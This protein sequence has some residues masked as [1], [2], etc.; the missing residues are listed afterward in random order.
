MNA[1]TINQTSSIK[2]INPDTAGIDIGAAVHFVAVPE[3]R[4]KEIVKS[5]ECYTA[6]IEKMIQ[7]L[8]QCKIRTVVMESTGS[9]WI[10]VFE[11][12]DQ[13]GFKVELVDAHHVKNVRGRKSDVIDCQWLQQLHSYGLLSAAF[14]PTDEIAGLRSYLRQ[15][16]MLIETAARHVQHAQ[17]ALVQMNLHLHNAIND[18]T[19][20]TGMAIIRAILSGEKSPDVLAKMRDPR[21]KQSEEVIKKSLQGNYREEHVFALRQAIETYDFYQKKIAECDEEIKKN[22][23]N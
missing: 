6:G 18:I 7:W 23:K 8:K 22:F 14:R 11:M 12:L 2:I 9:Y 21:C 1:E 15:R 16:T 13:A 19:G 10:P 20:V 17:K 4:D 5:F 3:G